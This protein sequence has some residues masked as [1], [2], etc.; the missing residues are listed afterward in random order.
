[1]LRRYVSQ[2]ASSHVFHIFHIRIENKLTDQVTD[3]VS[4]RSMLGKEHFQITLNCVLAATY[5]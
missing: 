3:Q 2:E 1:M 4:Y 5:M